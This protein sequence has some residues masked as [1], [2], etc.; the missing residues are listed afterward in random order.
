MLH[1]SDECYV[2][3]KDYKD[4]I[5]IHIRYYER[6]GNGKYPTKKGITLNLSRWLILER[7]KDEINELFTIRMEGEKT[8]EEEK[9]HLGGG[10]YVTISRKFPTVDLRHFW[11]PEDSNIP[12]PTKRG[13]ALIQQMWKHLCE[14]MELIRDFVPEL[15]HE[16]I[17]FDTH[18]NQ[19]EQMACNEC[20]LFEP[21]EEMFEEEEISPNQEGD[22][23]IMCEA[24]QPE[25]N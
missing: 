18:R 1:I 14:V 24:L 2:V 13:V 20:C 12:V 22:F 4:G 15:D 17:C 3:A 11:K 9:I 10:L 23:R 5:Y 7:Y 16:L 19:N 6:K 21:K 25:D 8:T